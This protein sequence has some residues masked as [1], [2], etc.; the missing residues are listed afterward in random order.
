MLL[1]D[2]P[3]ASMTSNEIGG[4]GIGGTSADQGLRRHS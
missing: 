1:Q 4:M 3:V 2:C